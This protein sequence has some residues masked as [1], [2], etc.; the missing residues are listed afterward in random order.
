MPF[1]RLEAFS[2]PNSNLQTKKTSSFTTLWTRVVTSMRGSQWTLSNQKINISSTS[3]QTLLTRTIRSLWRIQKSSKSLY[4]KPQRLST[5]SNTFFPFSRTLKIHSVLRLKATF[6][7][8]NRIH[9]SPLNQPRPYSCP[10][11][12]GDGIE[13]FRIH[14]IEMVIVVGGDDWTWLRGQV[15]REV[16]EMIWPTWAIA[17]AILSPFTIII[18]AAI[19]VG[20]GYGIAAWYRGSYEG[21]YP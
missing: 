15:S 16:A 5:T 3:A 12:W 7:T 17:L 21:Q 20:W 11:S 8:T 6:S 18:M 1:C 14:D 4:L 9:L 2:S 10:N 13:T 19:K